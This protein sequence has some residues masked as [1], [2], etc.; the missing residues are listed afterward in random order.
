MGRLIPLVALN[1]YI[2]F[3]LEFDIFCLGFFHFYLILNYV[4]LQ[5]RAKWRNA[6]WMTAQT[7]RYNR[8][9]FIKPIIYMN[10]KLP[11][12]AST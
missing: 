12:L 1:R 4:V 11:F 2:G 8:I 5:C 9:E 3:I 7:N 10:S 6:D